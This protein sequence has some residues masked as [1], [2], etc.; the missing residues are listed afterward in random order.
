[1]ISDHFHKIDKAS[2]AGLWVAAGVLVIVCQFIAFVMVA[3][4]QVKKAELREARLALE[5]V[6]IANCMESSVGAARHNCLQQ[7]RA[8]ESYVTAG[9]TVA[10]ATVSYAQGAP[11]TWRSL[12]PVAFAAN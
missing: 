12:V 11:S 5:R 10:P 3:Q 1:M 2:G 4:G 8:G 7:A 6:A 9:A